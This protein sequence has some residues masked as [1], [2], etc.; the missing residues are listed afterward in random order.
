V[1]IEKVNANAIVAIRLNVSVFFK[2]MQFIEFKE[3]N[4]G[5]FWMKNIN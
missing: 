2:A 3:A 4:K 1:N 5:A